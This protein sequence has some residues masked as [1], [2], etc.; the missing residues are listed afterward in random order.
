MLR[1]FLRPSRIVTVLGLV[2]G[3]PWGETPASNTCFVRP[4]V[5]DTRFL[6]LR[7]LIAIVGAGISGMDAK[8]RARCP[9]QDA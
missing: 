5:A 6:L 3:A 2:G 9:H 8:P 7:D 4:V 1:L